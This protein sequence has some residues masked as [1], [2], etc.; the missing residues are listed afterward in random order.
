M[1][2]E[3][4]IIM[5][6]T[7]AIIALTIILVVQEFKKVNKDIVYEEKLSRSNESLITKSLQS[8][9]SNLSKQMTTAD[10]DLQANIAIGTAGIYQA[11]SSSNQ[12]FDNKLR[13]VAE[14]TASLSVGV[15]SEMDDMDRAFSLINDRMGQY[16]GSRSNLTENTRFLSANEFIISNAQ[17]QSRINNDPLN[18]VTVS[19]NNPMKKYDLSVPNLAVGTTLNVAGTL[20]FASNNSSYMLGVDGT[21]MYLKLDDSKDFIIRD[22]KDTNKLSVGRDNV[23]IDGAAFNINNTTQ[24]YMF[25][26]DG[27]DLFLK[28]STTDGAFI[29]RDANNNSRLQ[30]K[31]DNVTINAKTQASGDIVTSTQLCINQ[32]CVNEADL[33][34]MKA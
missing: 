33:T 22:N 8:T 12:I 13:K 23:T 7:L 17:T 3:S 34:R 18:G 31:N 2:W 6:V 30:V 15:Y 28:P 4:I 27:R 20:S 24:S 26:L 1:A 19:N 10:K 16:M 14:E 29:V 21:S 25:N 9:A 32:T 5:V 11:M